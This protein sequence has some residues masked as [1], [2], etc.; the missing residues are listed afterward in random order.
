[1]ARGGGFNAFLRAA[2]RASAAAQREHNRAIRAQAATVRQLERQ[3][4]MARV[5]QA[6]DQRES[7]KAAKQQYLEDRIA[8]TDDLNAELNERLESFRGLLAYTLAVD[9][10]ISFNDLRKH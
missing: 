5:Q 9:D 6:R 2:A 8:E 4:R 10:R 1:M 3:E 7:E